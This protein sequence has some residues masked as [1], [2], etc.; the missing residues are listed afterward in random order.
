V[1]AEGLGADFADNVGFPSLC[2]LRLV[3]LSQRPN[4]YATLHFVIIQ[5]SSES[6]S[7]RGFW[8]DVH[9]DK[10]LLA[11]LRSNSTLNNASRINAKLQPAENPSLHCTKFRHPSVDGL[12]S[13]ENKPDKS[14]KKE[15]TYKSGASKNTLVL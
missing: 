4:Y 13:V 12:H 10:S 6:R 15:L 8:R 3:F 7:G 11:R 2:N 14:A 5:R 1:C 9:T